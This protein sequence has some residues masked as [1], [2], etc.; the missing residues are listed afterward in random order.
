M[1][2]VFPSVPLASFCF[3]MFFRSWSVELAPC[4]QMH[5]CQNSR[6]PEEVD[7]L[8]HSFATTPNEHQWAPSK[9][10]HNVNS[11][12]SFV[13]LMLQGDMRGIPLFLFLTTASAFGFSLLFPWN[14]LKHLLSFASAQR[15]GPSRESTRDTEALEGSFR[16]TWTFSLSRICVCLVFSPFSHERKG[17]EEPKF[18]WLAELSSSA[19][20]GGSSARSPGET[21]A[22]VGV[23]LE[24]GFLFGFYFYFYFF[25]RQ[26]VAPPKIVSL[27]E[28][29]TNF[30]ASSAKG[31]PS[32]TVS[33]VF[34]ICFL[35]EK[36][37]Q[38]ARAAAMM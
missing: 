5:M 1:L 16:G 14:S 11:L 9:L 20:K 32:K 38:P 18:L 35:N 30:S 31:A 15:R 12:V 27:F 13:G 8:W 4:S 37:F 17:A 2:L 3:G 22:D 28:K 19:R 29:E 23:S 6:D 34:C 36:P 7:F 25:V 33:S 24:L 21:A 10:E 26:H